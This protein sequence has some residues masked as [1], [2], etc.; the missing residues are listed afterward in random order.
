MPG[1][2]QTPVAEIQ[3][4]LDLLGFAR[5][6]GSTAGRIKSTVDLMLELLQ[7]RLLVHR[8]FQ[9]IRV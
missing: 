5:G 2:V 9:E 3:E 6:W 8:S 4:Q 1:C 7:A